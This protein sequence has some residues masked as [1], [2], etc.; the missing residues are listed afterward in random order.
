MRSLNPRRRRRADVKAPAS[1]ARAAPA[2]DKPPKAGV[3][4]FEGGENWGDISDEE[5]ADGEAEGDDEDD[6][7]LSQAWTILDPPRVLFEKQLPGTQSDA[8]KHRN[9]VTILGNIYGLLGEVR[10]ESESFA[11]TAKRS[12]KKCAS[13]PPNSSKKPLP[14]AAAV[15]SLKMRSCK[16]PRILKGRACKDDASKAKEMEDVK[17]MIAELEQRLQN[18]RMPPK[19]K[20][21]AEKEAVKRL[22]G[23]CWG[24]IRR[25]RRG[26]WGSWWEGR[27]IS[28]G[29]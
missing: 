21:K 4:H 29:W 16:K 22:L 9:L 23:N 5:D 24:R 27:M 19:N 6:D 14:P 11:Q 17:E 10:L 3:L 26:S 15:L 13:K 25:R 20:E 18:L 2:Q 7:K 28:R 12:R 8:E 1:S